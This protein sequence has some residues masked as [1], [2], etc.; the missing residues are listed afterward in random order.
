VTEVAAV[1]FHSDFDA[2]VAGVRASTEDDSIPD[3]TSAPAGC[4]LR[5]LGVLSVNEV[6]SAISSLPC[7]Q[8]LSDPWP[9]RLLKQH[10]S[11]VAPFLTSLIS[12]FTWVPSSLP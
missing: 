10:S 2:K 6:T 1:D 4:V 3:C 5:D 12:L 11:L 9:T 8:C 7:K